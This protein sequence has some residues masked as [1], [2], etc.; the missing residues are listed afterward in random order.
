MFL[1]A[2]SVHLFSL[3][4]FEKSVYDLSHVLI[5]YES[6]VVSCLLNCEGVFK[7]FDFC[8]VQI[9]CIHLLKVLTIIGVP[10]WLSH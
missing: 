6:F 10:G 7:R 3:T 1:C 2:L 9:Y 5:W 4:D 8:A